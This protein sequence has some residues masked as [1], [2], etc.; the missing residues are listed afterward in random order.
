MPIPGRH[1]AADRHLKNITFDIEHKLLAETDLRGTPVR[2]QKQT[3]KMMFGSYPHLGNLIE[4]NTIEF[5][6]VYVKPG[7]RQVLAPCQRSERAK[8]D[9]VARSHP[10]GLVH[11]PRK[12]SN[13]RR[14]PGAIPG[15]AARPI[16]AALHLRRGVKSSRAKSCSTR[17]SA[18]VP[19]EP[20]Q[21]RW[22]AASSEST[23]IRRT[24][25][26]PCCRFANKIHLRLLLLVGRAKYPAKSELVVMLHIVLRVQ[27]A[28]RPPP[29]RQL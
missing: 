7:K 1:Q 19:P 24:S 18:P 3:S 5:I 8:P 26:W 17:S 4:N 11:V 25:K 10:A 22:A 29:S 15:K 12:T 6:N 13:A 14:S 20:W 28:K 21:K 16:D 23:S 27:P 9:G 2:W